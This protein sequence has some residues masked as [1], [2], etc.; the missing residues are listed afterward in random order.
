MGPPAEVL[1]F[2]GLKFHAFH[3]GGAGAGLGVALGCWWRTECNAVPGPA[4]IGRPAE[5]WRVAKMDLWRNRPRGAS[6]SFEK[7]KATCERW[8]VGTIESAV[9]TFCTVL[10]S[11]EGDFH[12]LD[13]STG[14]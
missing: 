3:E 7:R 14:K 13:K 6:P 1:K 5:H 2:P 10:D 9:R 4:R 11:A 12:S 8:V